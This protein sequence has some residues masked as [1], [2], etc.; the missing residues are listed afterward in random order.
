MAESEAAEEKERQQKEEKISEMQ[1]ELTKARTSVESI[2]NTVLPKNNWEDF[3]E[4]AG[5]IEKG[6][7]GTA[8]VST[9]YHGSDQSARTYQS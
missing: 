6:R 7:R 8:A 2:G 5:C 1:G 3:N 4:C 9:G